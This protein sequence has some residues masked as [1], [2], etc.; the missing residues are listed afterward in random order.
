MIRNFFA[1]P[2]IPIRHLLVPNGTKSE[3]QQKMLIS[4]AYTILRLSPSTLALVRCHGFHEPKNQKHAGCITYSMSHM[5]SL[6]VPFGYLPWPTCYPGRLTCPMSLVAVYQC[7]RLSNWLEVRLFTSSVINGIDSPRM[8]FTGIRY[9]MNSDIILSYSWRH[10]QVLILIW[11]WAL[12]SQPAWEKS[13]IS[14]QYKD[15]K[16]RA[17]RLLTL[18]W[19]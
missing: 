7:R 14:L 3:H 18:H 15:C 8:E 4:Y 19:K 1:Y 13:N 2:E 12:S 9:F 6:I 11:C 5:D 10:L 16:S 17:D